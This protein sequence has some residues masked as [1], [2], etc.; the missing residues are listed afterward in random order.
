MW[1]IAVGTAWGKLNV[2]SLSHQKRSSFDLPEVFAPG[3]AALDASRTVEGL[4]TILHSDPPVG[5]LEHF[6]S[7]EF[8]PGQRHAGGLVWSHSVRRQDLDRG[9]LLLVTVKHD[10]GD[11]PVSEP[12]LLLCVCHVV[13]NVLHDATVAAIA[14]ARP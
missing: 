6:F 4:Q 1:H 3:F 2:E 9:S 8:D 5:S 13:G 11:R 12:H 10:V 7:S 14:R